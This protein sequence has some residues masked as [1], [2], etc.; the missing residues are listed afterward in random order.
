MAT[1]NKITPQAKQTFLER[2]SATGATTKAAEA[3]KIS[4]NSWYRLRK[5]NKNFDN[6]CIEAKAMGIEVL[7]D[8]VMGCAMGD[9][10]DM[11]KTRL[12]AAF[13]LIKGNRPEYR[14]TYQMNVGGSLTVKIQKFTDGNKTSKESGI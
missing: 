2:L 9:G 11:S 6:D 1:P 3:T 13:F 4:R 7:I 5:R 14:D 12:T 8:K 10:P